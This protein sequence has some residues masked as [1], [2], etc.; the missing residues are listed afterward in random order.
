MHPYFEVLNPNWFDRA[1]IYTGSIGPVFNDFRYR[2][3]QDSESHVIHAATYTKVCYEQATD[4]VEADFTWDDNGI[5]SLKEWLQ[6][7]YNKYKA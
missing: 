4:K 6:S 3:T 7:Q 5:K 1:Y 2:F